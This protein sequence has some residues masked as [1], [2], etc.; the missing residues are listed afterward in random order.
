MEKIAVLGGPYTYSDLAIGE[1]NEKEYFP[2]IKDIFEAVAQKQVA[3]GLVPLEN[4]LEGPVAETISGLSQYNVEI[5]REIAFPIH[6][7]LIRKKGEKNTPVEMIY[8]HEQAL[9]QSRKFL[10]ENYKN[11][12]KKEFKSTFAALEA[13]IKSQ[14]KG[15]AAIA[16]SKA[17]ELRGLDIEKEDIG[18][19][20]TNHTLFVLIKSK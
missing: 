11:A 6:H 5:V 12:Q 2:C 13:L 20:K 8:S 9:A 3:Y 15:I 14:E 18:D 10:E 16:P 4:L 1:D 17:A 19:Q 7:C